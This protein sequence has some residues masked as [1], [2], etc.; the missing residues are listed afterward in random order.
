[1]TKQ[2]DF[3][4]LVTYLREKGFFFPS[5]QIYGG[6]ANTWDYGPLGVEIKNKLKAL[7]WKEFVTKEPNNIG[8]DTAI[9]MNPKVWEASGH[10]SN[11]S[12]PVVTCAFCKKNFR[13]DHLKLVHNNWSCPSCQRS[14]N[15]HDTQQALNLMFKVNMNLVGNDPLNITYLR[16]ETAQGIFVQFANIHRACRKK[17][18][19]GVGQIGKA[20]RNEVTPKD[21]IFRTKEFEQMELE[22]FFEKDFENHWNHYM[23][24]IEKFLTEKL[25]INKDNLKQ[26]NHPKEDLAHYSKQTIDFE[27]NFP[28]GWQELWGVAHRGNFDLSIHQQKSGESMEIMNDENKKII[29]EVIEPSVGVDRLILAII[30]NS[31]VSEKDPNSDREWS[32]LALPTC[33]APYIACILPLSKQL[34]DQAKEIRLDLLDK[35]LNV[36]YDETASIGKRYARQDS[37]G[38]PYCITIDFE[39]VNDESVTIRHRDTTKQ[40]RIKIKDIYKYLSNSK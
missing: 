24:K 35:D 25:E 34:I 18:P 36:T 1:M 40:E 22:F 21:F 9:F 32:Y 12:D 30:C 39:T 29:P 19:F 14:N 5:S 28:F 3:Q 15:Y 13:G 7:W 33:V 2:I 38:T 11:F 26:F 16:P 8:L 27:F 37:I 20:F 4:E 23:T 10:T 31:F 17:L 6:I